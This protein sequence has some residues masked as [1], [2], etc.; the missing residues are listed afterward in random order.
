MSEPEKS[1]QRQ[2]AYKV[3][4]SDLLA[5]FMMKDELSAGYIKISGMNAS[6]V[7]IIAIVVL[8]SEEPS[9]SSAGIDDGTGRISLKSFE[10][11]AIFSNVDVGDCVLVVGKIR[12]YN[13]EKYIIPEAM[14]KID[15]GWM[16]H[17]KI[18]LERMPLSGNSE[19]GLVIEEVAGSDDE[20]YSLIKKMDEGEG[21][22]FESVISSSKSA[23]A[24]GIIKRL[25][26]SGDIFEI[27]PGKLKVLE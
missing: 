12:Q 1:F 10:N 9:Y 3:R 8:K 23:R 2:V 7:N 15:V 25:L 17:R 16:N 6:R 14:K 11:K 18:E 21:V 26:E 24:E 20:V 5:G 4:I 19:H 22:S 27:K 13:D